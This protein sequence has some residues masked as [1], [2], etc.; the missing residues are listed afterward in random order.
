MLVE[1]ACPA[2]ELRR[3]RWLSLRQQRAAPAPTAD[4]ATPTSISQL[5][6]SAVTVSRATS[7]RRR[8]FSRAAAPM[9]AAYRRRA[10]GW[11]SPVR[12]GAASQWIAGANAF[13]VLPAN[14][15]TG[16]RALARSLSTRILP[17]LLAG[18]ANMKRASPSRTLRQAATAARSRTSDGA[19]S[20]QH[21]VPESWRGATP[22]PKSASTR[23][24]PV[25]RSRLRA[26]PKRVGAG[27]PTPATLSAS[28]SRRVSCV[29]RATIARAPRSTT[30]ARSRSLA[31]TTCWSRA[32]TSHCAR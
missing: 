23:T 20:R 21:V 13:L 19:T 9:G 28:Q 12:G 27:T 22:S 3:Q 14:A 15:A 7:G 1:E 6:T 24:I 2:R 8:S 31:T 11:R 16:S 18:L 17:K 32:N 26:L 5:A 25:R 4:R 30:Q 10:A 29:M